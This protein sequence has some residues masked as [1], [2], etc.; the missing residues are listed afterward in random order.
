MW[1]EWEEQDQSRQT[2]K[3]ISTCTGTECR[4]QSLLE[5]QPSTS[6]FLEQNWSHQGGLCRKHYILNKMRDSWKELG[7]WGYIRTPPWNA[8]STDKT[9]C[10]ISAIT[11]QQTHLAADCCSPTAVQL[12]RNPPLPLRPATDWRRPLSKG[13]STLLAGTAVCSMK[14]RLCT[15]AGKQGN[16][17][18]EA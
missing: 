4:L 11:L 13:T 16:F 5:V 14:T 12:G 1:P 8:C 2:A 18:D 7:G 3:P 6:R 10:C 9:S 15:P 17:I